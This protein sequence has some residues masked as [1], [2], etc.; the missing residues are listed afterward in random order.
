MNKYTF[1]K[2]NKIILNTYIHVYNRTIDTCIL[3]IHYYYIRIKYNTMYNAY[4]I[5]IIC[6]GCV[7][8]YI[9]IR[10]KI[11]QNM[12]NIICLIIYTERRQNPSKDVE[13]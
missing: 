2:P 10:G 9:Y 6:V 12:K 5:S 1:C 7:C 8:I 13:N 11:I 4:M 3:Y